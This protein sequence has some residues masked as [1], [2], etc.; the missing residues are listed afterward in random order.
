MRR[1]REL[2]RPP[3]RP[4]GPPPGRSRADRGRH[5][6]V[7]APRRPPPRPG[8]L[9]V[10]RGTPRRA[11]PGRGASAPPPAAARGGGGG[12]RAAAVPLPG[13][14]DGP[15]VPRGGPLGA[16]GV[17]VR[18]DGGRRGGGPAPGVPRRRRR[19]AAVAEELHPA[20][21]P[22]ERAAGL[23]PV[24]PAGGLHRVGR[25][26]SGRRGRGRHPAAGPGRLARDQRGGRLLPA[27]G[28]GPGGVRAA[29][30]PLP[31]PAGPPGSRRRGPLRRVQ[32]RGRPVP[33]GP[34]RFPAGGAPPR[35][36]PGRVELA[37]PGRAGAV[38]DGG[39]DA[40]GAPQAAAGV[41][42]RRGEA[43]DRGA[44][45]TRVGAG[46]PGSAVAGGERAPLRRGRPGAGGRVGALPFVCREVSGAR[47][48]ARADA[49][50]F[51]RGHA[52]RGQ[53]V[54]RGDGVRDGGRPRPA[55]REWYTRPRRAGRRT[56]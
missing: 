9:G 46:Q 48:R 17:R 28:A 13:L 19:G 25:A 18:A 53:A 34:A 20:G 50:T 42:R 12:G 30:L 41:Q 16:G 11:T 33:G 47:R 26:A 27:G 15:H 22:G 29:A 5:R 23:L 8:P 43:G 1:G 24:G 32:E 4:A 45:P 36:V 37:A 49:G 39:H 2:A 44:R 6:P 52:A 55:G 3:R 14:R 31:A 56:D 10:V 54:P 40:G 51:L 38:L 21:G 35:A 7:P